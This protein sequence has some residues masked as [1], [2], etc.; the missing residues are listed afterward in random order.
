MSIVTKAGDKGSTG[1]V[2][3]VRVPPRM[4]GMV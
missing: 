1:L 2:V 3:G 4:A